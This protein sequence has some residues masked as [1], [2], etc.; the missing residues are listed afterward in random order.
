M[1]ASVLRDPT[2]AINMGFQ[3]LKEIR[4]KT[5]GGQ[6]IS[7]NL[8]D[9]I[10]DYA[11][12]GNPAS[13]QALL[14]I[15]TLG[16]LTSYMDKFLRMDGK[17]SK[18]DPVQFEEIMTLTSEALA[19][20][21][22]VLNENLLTKFAEFFVRLYKDLFN[23]DIKFDSGKDVLR[24]IK[25]YNKSIDNGGVFSSRFKKLGNEGA[26]GKLT[27]KGQIGG[28]PI[29]DLKSFEQASIKLS[30]KNLNLSRQSMSVK[31]K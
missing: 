26:K 1:L 15:Q 10:S 7:Q 4:A 3:L 11:A 17:E 29:R 13:A 16:D 24:F 12:N 14:E 18:I 9:R 22:L 8:R 30:K 23:V 28:V 31:N 27:K 21:D 20:K 19:S 25:D 6:E 2:T 5:K